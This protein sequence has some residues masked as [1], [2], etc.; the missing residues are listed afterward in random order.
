[1]QFFER[2]LRA[3]TL[4]AG[5]VLF[6]LMLFTVL[7]VVLRYGFNRPFA[8]SVASTELANGRLTP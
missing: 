4:L 7:D 8:H 5:V 2:V 6:G 1:M 3:M